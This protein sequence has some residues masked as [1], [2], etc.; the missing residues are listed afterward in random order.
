MIKISKENIGFIKADWC[1]DPE[2]EDNIKAETDGFGS[3]CIAEE[4][5]TGKCVYCG[6]EAK[7][8][9]FWGKSY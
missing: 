9:V 7:H 3:R 5:P 8:K 2:C 6:K 1:G 4:K